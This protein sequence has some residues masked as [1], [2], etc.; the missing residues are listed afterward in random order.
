MMARKSVFSERGNS[1]RKKAAKQAPGP[2]MSDSEI[3]ATLEGYRQEAEM[4]RQGGQNSRDDKWKENLDLY[5]N[6]YDFSEK[7]D[8]QAKETLATVPAFVDRFA[9]AMKDALVASQD[10]FYTINDPGD[11]EGDLKEPVKTMLDAMLA[12][13]GRNYSGDPLGFPS[14]FEEQMKLGA[15]M[16]VC[17]V[18]LW[19]DDVPGGRVA[20]ESVDPRNCWLDATY[21][22]LYRIRRIE[23]DRH[24]VANM[25]K[26]TD[27]AGQP[28]FNQGEILRYLDGLR[29]EMETKRAEISGTGQNQ[30]SVRK[31]VV[32]DEYYATVLNA[33]GLMEHDKSLAVVADGEYL[34]RRPEE[35]PFLHGRD[36]VLYCPLVTAPLSP[37]GRTYMEDFGSIAKT[38]NSLTNMIL[39]A[40]Q[41]SS[42]NVFAI[43]PSLLLN[44]S[45]A[46]S[47]IWPRKLF[48]LEEG[49]DPNM[50]MAQL[51]MGNLPA[52]ALKVWESLKE[53][54]KEAAG[55]NDIGLGQF[56]P[57][58]R[59]SATEITET[60]QSSNALIRSVA[61]TVE[62]CF[63]NPQLDL[64]WKTGL[65]HLTAAN[66]DMARVVG[67]DMYSAL[68]GRKR[69]LIRRPYTFQAQGISRMLQKNRQ[70]RVLMQALQVMASNE[71]LLQAFL[72]EVDMTRLVEVIFD[73]SDL[74]IRK[75]QK[76]DRQSMIDEITR[77]LMQAQQAAQAGG[78]VGGQAQSEAGQ[79][80]KAVEGLGRPAA[81]TQGR[82]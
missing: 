56:A 38:F 76:S 46:A 31:S 36:W 11:K 58:S 63:L 2:R 55:L 62:N 32:L 66:T 6:R 28:V 67:P 42:L 79:V 20:V 60:Q 37:Y 61:E 69:E 34:F 45:Q 16:A 1:P 5:W 15:L 59:T 49:V 39:D 52:E 41:A 29:M 44:P 33:V 4:A 73:L 40:V 71:I 43:V 81:Q 80:A 54:L 21:R 10:G 3:V 51:P 65:Q 8:W 74:D 14:V 77:P 23:L 9:G 26:E 7:A 72:Q 25:A 48:Q 53:E 68:I 24:E 64:I 13:T 27:E 78:P 57:N 22:G 17:T 12:R 75:L 19:K 50:F 70:M 18:T 82:A 35:N 30:T 47:G